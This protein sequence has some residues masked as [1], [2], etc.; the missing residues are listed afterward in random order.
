MSLKIIK[1]GV[2]DTVQDKGRFGYQHLGVNP[3]GVMDDFSAQLANAL[4]GK[5]LDAPVIEMHFPSSGLLFQKPTIICIT[6]ADFK[7]MVE[8]FELPLHQPVFIPAQTSLQFK[9]VRW[10]V[11]AYL[12]T[13]Q[14]FILTP[15]LH[16]YS[17]NV[18]AEAGGYNGRPLKGGDILKYENANWLTSKKQSI[19]VLHWKALGVRDLYQMPV[20]FLKGNEWNWLTSDSQF[21]LENEMF[22]ISLEA[23]RMGYQLK[24][25]VLE[26]K[27][28]K[29]LI[30]S[31]VNFG[32]MQLLP[33]GQL[34]VLMADHQTTG[35]YPRV[36]H[37]ISAHIPILAQ[38]KPGELVYFKTTDL[39]SAE[40]KFIK[41]QHYL[42]DI[43]AGAKLNL[44]KLKP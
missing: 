28:S 9:T 44:Q 14:D 4:L 42:I 33:N 18:K 41:Q 21:F 8:G 20:H 36:G 12:A 15:W 32:T 27:D 6:G 11:R 26:T 19:E 24:G 7:P 30:S 1:A 43:Q 3:N 35:G 25:P 38:R 29:Q 23:D 2:L 5:K 31:A 10:G 37:V 40:E 17:T 16:S 39:E 34:I 22:Q 13:L